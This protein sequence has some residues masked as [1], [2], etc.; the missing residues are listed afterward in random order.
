MV[1]VDVLVTASGTLRVTVPGFWGRARH[2]VPL[3]GAP[4]WT[5]FGDSAA[6]VD[7]QT[8][9]HPDLIGVRAVFFTGLLQ[10]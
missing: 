4:L 10:G 3:R 2:A 8:K 7:A 5:L 6:K 1:F 9:E